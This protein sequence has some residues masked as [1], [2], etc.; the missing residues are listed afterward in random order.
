MKLKFK[1]LS[2]TILTLSSTLL[3]KEPLAKENAKNPLIQVWNTPSQ[4]PPFDKIKI[5]HYLPAFQFAITQA[6]QEIDA[7]C[8]QRSVPTFENTIVALDRAGLLL[9]KISGV[10]FNVSEAES[11]PE[12][13][14]VAKEA[15]P[16]ITTYSNDLSLNE[17]LF[18]R[19]KAVYEQK[20]K[21]NLNEEQGMLLEKTYKS[22]AR[23]GANLNAADKEKYRKISQ[24]LSDLSLQFNE[25]VLKETNAYILHITN[26]A[27]L[28]GLPVDARDQAAQL[29]KAKNLD[30]WVFDLSQP[31]YFAF[32]RY[33]DNREL[34]KQMF[35]AYNT[36][37]FQGNE[38]DNQK[39][40][41]RLTQLR[42]ELAQLLGYPTYS[43]Y[44]LEERMAENSKKVNTFLDQLLKVSLPYAKKDLADL[45]A[46]A[47]TLGLT[48]SLERW[49]FGYYSEKLRTAKYNI[50][51]EVLK[52]YFELKS[53]SK[54][55]FELA[56]RLYGLKFVLNT[57][58]VP[59]QKDVL[60]YDV[61]DPSGKEMAVLYID[62][63]ARSTK[64]GGAWMTAFREQYVDAKGKDVR[65]IISLVLNFP[66]PV[67][68][69]PVLLTFNDFSTFLHEFGHALHGMLSECTYQ[70]TSGTNVPRDFVELPSQLM[71]NWG[72]QKE[73]LDLFAKHY[74]TG[75][76]LSPELIKKLVDAE[77]FQAGYSSIRQLMF[78]ILD[79]KWHS[80]TSPN[81]LDVPVF[82]T[83]A[84][85][86]AEADDKKALQ[87]EYDTL[88]AKLIDQDT[89]FI[90]FR[91]S[92]IEPTDLRGIPV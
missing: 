80:L 42:L 27:D 22:F 16:L 67:D 33:A 52:P 46:Y 69:G 19:V 45:Q 60:I 2:M 29:A 6:R 38:N 77:N 81:T 35:T 65:P 21:L 47:K 41:L 62:F 66:A 91:L 92:Q 89:N 72:T 59:Y 12:T 68:N 87:R 61:F 49:D 23:N 54:G 14:A 74:K 32:I 84:I 11:T 53:V 20:D 8:K 26:E 24:E 39:V 83:Q 76:N 50:N 48:D 5:A 10:F 55:I 86:E 9:N 70:S 63:Y 1:M 30:G 40:V 36:R 7:I 57:Q 13:Q 17:A 88:N 31:S 56:N 51:D 85:A 4:T 18:Q 82:E 37:A 15:M 58:I 44:V 73:F 79:M 34:R 25:N 28:S 64:K 90:D 78:A 43:D 75:E 3:A 71:E